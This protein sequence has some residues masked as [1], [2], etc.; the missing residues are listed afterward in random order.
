MA[1]NLKLL[2]ILRTGRKKTSRI[3]PIYARVTIEGKRAEWS[4]QREWDSTKWDKKTCRP[5]GIKEE[6]KALS[7]YLDTLQANIFEVQRDYA[8]RRQF[9]SSE[10]VKSEI[11]FKKEDQKYSLIE[12]YQ[13]QNDQIR[14]LVEIEY[15]AGTYRMFKSTLKNLKSFLEWKFKRPDVKLTD[16]NHKL[17]TDFE[18]YLKTVKRLQHNSAMGNIKKLKKIIRICIANDWLEKDPFRSYKITA[19]ETHR[20]FLSREELQVLESIPI[21]SIKLDQTRDIFLFSCYTGLSYSD[22]I[23]LT[24]GNISTGIDGELW[25]FTTRIK[26]DTASRIPLLSPAKS[27]LAKYETDP[28]TVANQRLLP[29]ISNQKINYYLK[30]LNELCGF[31]KHLTFH[32]ARHTFATTVTLSNGIPIES[33]SKMLGHKSLKTTQHYAKVLD[34]KISEDMQVLRNKFDARAKENI[35]II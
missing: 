32:M 35:K 21:S 31:G 19:K 1:Q 34:R 30:A 6:A 28:K 15:S 5:I 2:F 18:F 25:V 16:V 29:L 33:V 12:V 10:A 11:Q 23:N 4:I 24:A 3:L 9:L 17:I 13:Y 14:Q 20:Q 26:T 27:I 8:L 22:V 7:R